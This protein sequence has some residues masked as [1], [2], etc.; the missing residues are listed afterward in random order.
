MTC[1]ATTGPI[2]ETDIR[3][4]FWRQLQI[5]GSTM[6]NHKEFSDVLKL[7]WAGKLKAVIDRVLPLQDA[8]KAQQ[9]MEQRAQFGKLVLKP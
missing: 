1:G 8:A 4:V 3:Y 6:S 5:L 9:L 2:G 7:I